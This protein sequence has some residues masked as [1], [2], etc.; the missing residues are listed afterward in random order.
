MLFSFSIELDPFSFTQSLFLWSKPL[1]NCYYK[2]LKFVLHC[3]QFPL[4]LLDLSRLHSTHSH[5]YPIPQIKTIW[6][7]CDNSL[8]V[9]FWVGGCLYVCVCVRRNQE[10]T[11]K[12]LKI[13][14][15]YQNWF[16]SKFHP[17]LTSDKGKK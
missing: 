16:E 4:Y 10:D 9:F 3:K 6:N 2:T 7:N 8:P 17:T 1:A 14:F 11:S 12:W 5:T 13:V 15:V